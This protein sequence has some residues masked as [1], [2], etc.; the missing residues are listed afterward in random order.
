MF[1]IV[2]MV[3][4]LLCYG[5]LYYCSM[6]LLHVYD[7]KRIQ[8]RLARYE[9]EAAAGMMQSTLYVDEAKVPAQYVFAQQPSSADN[10]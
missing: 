1:D 2:S 7:E 10:E 9:A 6:S 5:L 8:K 4:V 3:I